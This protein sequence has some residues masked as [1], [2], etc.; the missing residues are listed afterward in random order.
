MLCN[1]YNFHINSYISFIKLFIS[2]QQNKQL[3]M[4]SSKSKV[5][6]FKKISYFFKNKL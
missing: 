4:S 5:S 6:S 1:I 3:F 2:T